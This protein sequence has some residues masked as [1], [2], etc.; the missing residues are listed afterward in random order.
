MK[1]EYFGSNTGR[2]APA[3]F[4]PGQ[5]PDELLARVE[6]FRFPCREYPSEET[7]QNELAIDRSYND[8]S[9]YIVYISPVDRFSIVATARI[10]AK[11]NNN[12]KLPVEFSRVVS[13]SDP[14]ARPAPWQTPGAFFNAAG[15]E[16][17]FPVCEIGG[18]RAAETNNEAGIT[19]LLRYQAIDAVMK[20][21]SDQVH[22]R[23]FSLFF[24]TCLATPHMERLYKDKYYFNEVAVINYGTEHVWKALWRWPFVVP[25]EMER[26]LR[27]KGLFTEAHSDRQAEPALHEISY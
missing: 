15:G 23:N 4:D 3:I 6:Q 13:I 20:A 11:R 18:L 1:A 14:V 17:V 12:E 19:K 25:E 22:L 24:L 7:R 16:D 9:V 10:I 27:L 2:N 26:C 8:R 21:C 5:I